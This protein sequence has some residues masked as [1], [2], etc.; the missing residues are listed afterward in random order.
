MEFHI[1]TRKR[2]STFQDSTQKIIFFYSLCLYFHLARPE[3][4]KLSAVTCYTMHQVRIFRNINNL[5]N[6][7]LRSRR[8]ISVIYL[9]LPSFKYKIESFCTK[10]QQ[11]QIYQKFKYI[12]HFIHNILQRIY[13]NLK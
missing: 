11:V 1:K 4:S 8:L 2:H 5:K 10:W 6:I 12:F 9:L 3:H 13:L 7:S